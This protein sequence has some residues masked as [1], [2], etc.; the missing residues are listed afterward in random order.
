[1]SLYHLLSHQSGL[2]NANPRSSVW[3]ESLDSLDDRAVFTDPG[4]VFSYSRYDYPLAL[5][6]LEQSIEEDLATAANRWVFEPL[7]MVKTSLG[8]AK[9][10]LPV[11]LTTTPDLLRFGSALAEKEGDDLLPL[12]TAP[13]SPALRDGVGRWFDGGFWRDFV[14]GNSRVSLMCSAGYA[15]DAAGFQ[16]FPESGAVLVF[17]S[18]SRNPDQGWPTVA[19][20][21]LLD[22]VGSDLGVE[23]NLYESRHV[24]GDGQV[25]K[26]PRPCDEPG[27]MTVR[28]D[29]PGS[30]ASAGDWAGR[31]ENGDRVIELLD[32]EGFLRLLAGM[33]S[34]L[35]VLHFKDDTY[36]A[37]VANRPLWPF[38]LV[39]DESGRRYAILGDRAYIHEDDRPGN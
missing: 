35:E 33:G 20:R 37:T 19:A 5:R 25:D 18:R 4:S 6:A 31:Y 7:G 38:R 34:E 29:D 36:F 24:R 10:G 13:S 11:L 16:V 21:N 3:S 23:T 12:P 32:R 26:G 8:D 30:P 22:G 39:M 2:D 28:A 9:D 17:W 27:P 1:M 14:E 15:S